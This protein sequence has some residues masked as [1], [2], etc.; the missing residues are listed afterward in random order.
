M[1]GDRQWR[2]FA[3][4]TGKSQFSHFRCLIIC[5]TVVQYSSIISWQW[6][7]HATWYMVWYMR[8]MLYIPKERQG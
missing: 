3:R 1:W 5:S 6:I 8:Y 7:T 2:C 4:G